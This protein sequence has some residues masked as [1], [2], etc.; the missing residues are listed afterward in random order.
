MM[1]DTQNIHI[2]PTESRKKS[3]VPSVEKA[4]D[5]L[6]LLSVY[7]DGLTMKE[8]VSELERTMS[9]VYRITLYLVERGYL[10]Q[11]PVTAR[12]ALTLGLFELAHRHPPT[13]RLLYKAVPILEQI[14]AT[15]EQSCHL[16]VLNRSNVLILA[17]ETSPRPAG[18]AVRTGAMFDAAQTSTGMVIMAHSDHEAQQR[19][20]ERCASAERSAVRN[21][22]ARIAEQGYDDSPSRLVTGVR[23]LC[24]PVFNRRQVVG[25]IT[26]GYIEQTN[27]Y[28]SPEDT[29]RLIRECTVELS[30]ALGHIS[31]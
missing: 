30:R 7:R 28:F 26:C 10:E 15:A 29:L 6:E 8:L 11:D 27:Q 21:Q 31:R 1:T 4:F 22:L 23:N 14:A 2:K 19:F 16:G 20:L 5:I 3:S 9:E 17:S 12:Y 18:Y 13:E 25:A 24:A